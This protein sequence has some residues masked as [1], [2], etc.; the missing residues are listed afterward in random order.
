MTGL[1]F[2][3]P[4]YYQHSP[5]SGYRVL[6][7]RFMRWPDG[8]VLVVNEVGE[9]LFLDNGTF[10][11]FVQHRLPTG[12]ASYSSLKG[13]HFL[14]DSPSSVPLELLATKY[15]TKKSFLCGF[16]RL[17]LFVTT[18]R[19]D[20][21]CPYCQVSRVTEEKARYDM[22]RETAERAIDLMFQSPAPS[23]K[24][25]FQG[26]EPLLNFDLLRFIV[27]EVKRRNEAEGRVI[28]FVVATN[29]SPLTE[30]MLDF[31]REHSIVVST[32]LDGP[33]SIHDANRP[34]R[35]GGSHETTVRQIA[36]VREALGH[37]RVSALMTTTELSLRHPREIVDEYVRLGFDGIFLRPISPYGFAV[38]SGA[39]RRYQSDEFLVFYRT[40]LE[41]VVDVNRSGIDFV[42]FYA[43]LLLRKM[44]T[45]F[46]T[47]YVDL[48]SPAGTGISV[49]AYNYDGDV[50]A[51]DEA[52]MLAEMGDQTFRLGNVHENSYEQM[53]GG[54]LLRSLVAGSCVEALPGCWECAFAPYCGAD[55]VFHWA[56]QGDPVGHRP[57]SAFCARNMGIL[58]YL[59]GL[60]RANDPFLTRLFTSW[61]TYRRIDPPL[62]S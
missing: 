12:S 53:F 23:L 28:E 31:L 33:Q 54:E 46:A 26:G 39:D 5:T 45:P 10:A 22:S 21:S 29:L 25:E 62:P 43:Q 37:D 36:R 9:F 2:Q 30:E 20:H 35:G 4:E 60:L 24:V 40:A 61:A 13:K 51:S 1:A 34:R 19:C 47:G 38:R 11:A 56:T 6:P 57:T 8:D 3:P 32:S 49:V 42:E 16:T 15:R 27:E 41:H 44:L 48:Q 17:H 7:M 14:L 58:K 59:F 50:Y 18:L 52:R 55:P